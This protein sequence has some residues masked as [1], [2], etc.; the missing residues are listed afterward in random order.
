MVDSWF[1][2][3]VGVVVLTGAGDKSFIAGA[4]ISVLAKLR[5]EGDEE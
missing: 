4:D 2:T 3:Y 5:G 1:D